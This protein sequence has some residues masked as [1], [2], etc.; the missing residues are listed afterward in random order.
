MILCLGVTGSGKSMLL[1]CLK[2]RSSALFNGYVPAEVVVEDDDGLNQEPV[3]LL[4][5]VAT[6]GTDLVHLTKPGSKRNSPPQG[7]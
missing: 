4:A 1:H 6:V 3:P 7:S 2:E 5:A